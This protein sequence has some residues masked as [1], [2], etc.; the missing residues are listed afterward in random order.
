MRLR[1][2]LSYGYGYYPA[3]LLGIRN[4]HTLD[5][6][7]DLPVRLPRA[8]RQAVEQRWQQLEGARWFYRWL[9]NIGIVAQKV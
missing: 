1:P 5:Q 9:A 4:L 6:R 7:R 8:V 3:A 2:I